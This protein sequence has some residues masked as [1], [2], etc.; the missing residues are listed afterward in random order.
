MD[1]NNNNVRKK[2]NFKQNHYG[3][4]K[5][6]E[7]LD[8]INASVGYLPESVN[9]RD[10]DGAFTKMVESELAPIAKLMTKGGIVTEK[11]PVFFITM[12][13]WSEI[14]KTWDFT[15]DDKLSEITFPFMTIVRKPDVQVGTGQNGYYNIPGRRNWTYMKVPN[16]EHGRDGVDLYKIP[17]PT[18]IDLN[19]EVR[20]FTNYTSDLN[21]SLELIHKNYN[22]I[23]KYVVV[24]GHPMPTKNESIN[25]ESILGIDDRK[26]FSLSYDI[27]L[28]GYILDENDFEIVSTIDRMT[29]I[30]E[31]GTK[32]RKK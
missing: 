2:L 19:Y 6:Q 3:V 28:Q 32:K 26:L 14:S 8:E 30:E 22:A 16:T 31:F 27:L 20:V 24:K 15:T 5:R 17:Q 7:W 12:D 29:T 9:I 1:N 21:S 13:R 23:Q 10:I 18:S 25:D 11:M 4:P